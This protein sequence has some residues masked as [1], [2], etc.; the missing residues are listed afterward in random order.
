[1]KTKNHIIQSLAALFLLSPLAAFAAPDLTVKDIRLVK[2]CKIQVTVAN[3][4]TTGVPSS[5]YNLPKAVGVQMY[6]GSQ[7]WGGL[8]L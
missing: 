4:G 2:G 5:Y 8:I 6:K 1:M 3:I 7:A